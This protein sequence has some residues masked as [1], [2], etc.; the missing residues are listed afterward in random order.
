MAKSQRKAGG[1]NKKKKGKGKSTSKA[2]RSSARP[3]SAP[4]TSRTAGGLA[5]RGKKRKRGSAAAGRGGRSFVD[6]R[7]SGDL[8]EYIDSQASLPREPPKP[9]RGSA[10]RGGWCRG[11]SFR[12]EEAQDWALCD[13]DCGW[14]GHCMA[15]Y[16]GSDL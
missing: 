2:R 12:F 15:N 6:R 5:R 13:K 16:T 9:Q 10:H 8:S 11:D 7:S 4:A 1:T 3:A 14:C